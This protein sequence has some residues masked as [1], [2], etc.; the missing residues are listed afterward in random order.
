MIVSPEL[1]KIRN[2]LDKISKTLSVCRYI[3]NERLNL[4]APIVEKQKSQSDPV[5]EVKQKRTCDL[6]SIYKIHKI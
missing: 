2:S 1:A 4:K 6:V 3:S 5:E